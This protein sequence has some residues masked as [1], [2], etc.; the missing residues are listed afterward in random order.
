MPGQFHP[1]D[2][3]ANFPQTN[4]Y[5]NLGHKQAKKGGPRSKN[6]PPSAENRVLSTLLYRFFSISALWVVPGLYVV[7]RFG[8]RFAA[9]L[10]ISN[11]PGTQSE[12]L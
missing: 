3:Q 5:K 11:K 2:K 9:A 12:D 6:D 7:R 8:C 1:G 4:F 10:D